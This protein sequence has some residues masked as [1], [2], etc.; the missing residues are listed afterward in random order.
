[1][2]LLTIFRI[3]LKKIRRTHIFW[4]LLIPLI[5][6]W[7]PAVLNADSSFGNASGNELFLLELSG[8]VLVYVPR[9][10]GGDHSY[11]EPAGED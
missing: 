7:I 6:L 11:A 5:L 2:N 4:I 10:S 8:N 1:M 3:E 9:Q